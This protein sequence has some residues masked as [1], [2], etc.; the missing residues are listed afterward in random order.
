MEK[1]A[2]FFACQHGAASDRQVR[3]AGVSLKRQKALIASEIWK[4]LHT[5][6]LALSGSP[7][8]WEQQLIAATLA[9]KGSVACGRTAARLHGLDGFRRYTGINIAVPRSARRLKI[10]GVRF[11]RLIFDDE[12][13][14][15][16]KG[17]AATSVAVTLIH[18]APRGL[19]AAQPLDDALRRG[20]KP[21]EL[22][23]DFERWKGRGV[24]AAR[25]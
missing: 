14:T 17:I 11:T 25:D 12:D 15:I 4:R 13:T 2:A 10:P 21:A 6:V 24:R 7:D 3:S 18:L 23:A 9:V 20:S 19:N 5:G 22:R 8:T 1:W 16:V